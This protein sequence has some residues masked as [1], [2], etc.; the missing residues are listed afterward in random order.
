MLDSLSVGILSV[1]SLYTLAVLL[2]HMSKFLDFFIKIEDLHIQNLAIL[3]AEIEHVQRFN[4]LFKELEE[5]GKELKE[6]E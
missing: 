6:S 5:E 2:Y 3:K 1:E 4:E